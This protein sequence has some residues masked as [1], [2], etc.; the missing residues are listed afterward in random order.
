MI[1]VDHA[2]FNIVSPDALLL[3]CAD[4]EPDRETPAS[5]YDDA[6]TLDFTSY[7]NQVR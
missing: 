1:R 7:V 2:Q 3:F 5:E 6:E 4:E